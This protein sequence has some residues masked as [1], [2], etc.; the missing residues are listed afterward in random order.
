MD[1]NVGLDDVKSGLLKMTVG[2]QGLGEAEFAHQNETGTIG[3]RVVMVGVFAKNVLAAAKRA[4]PIH[5]T[6]MPAD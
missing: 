4:G 5:S 3:E 2:G 1:S 6:W